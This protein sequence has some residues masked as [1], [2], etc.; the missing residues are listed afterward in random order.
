[1]TL[2]LTLLQV[3]LDPGHR[4]VCF[5]LKG[6]VGESAS[7]NGANEQGAARVRNG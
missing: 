4:S 3:G 1:M 2:M 6:D 7:M 5:S